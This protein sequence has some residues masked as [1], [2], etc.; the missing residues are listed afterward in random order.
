[1]RPLE[2]K[3]I[4]GADNM[5]WAIVKRY[6]TLYNF[7]GLHLAAAEIAMR[8]YHQTT[9]VG[10]AAWGFFNADHEDLYEAV[11]CNGCQPLPKP[12]AL[13]P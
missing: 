13:S 3:R 11:P 1:M 5:T 4:F 6:V 9:L 12:R 7:S 10:W 8:P 2:K